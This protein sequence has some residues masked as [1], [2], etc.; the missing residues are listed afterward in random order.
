M[1]KARVAAA[2]ALALLLSAASIAPAGAGARPRAQD[3]FYSV[4]TERR[5]E[6]TIGELLF[7]PRY[8]DRAPFLI[9]VVTEKGTDKLFRVEVSP[10]WF[11]GRDLDLHKGEGVKIVGSYYV[12]DGVDYLIARQL[13]AGGET[14]RLRDS[15]G[16]PTWRGGAANRKGWRR[17]RGM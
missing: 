14:F 15:R 8:E 17:G 10:V 13:Q 3:H 6:G 9:L 4:D 2:V 1:R 16:F 11:F 12:K 5:V 7:E